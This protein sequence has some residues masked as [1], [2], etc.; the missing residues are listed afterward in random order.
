MNDDTRWS[1]RL[2]LHKDDAVVLALLPQ[3][4]A[5]TPESRHGA[6]KY[7]SWTVI[8]PIRKK[9]MPRQSSSLWVIEI[10]GDVPGDTR[11]GYQAGRELCAMGKPELHV[12]ECCCC[13]CGEFGLLGF[14]FA[15]AVTGFEFA[16]AMRR[17]VVSSLCGRR[18]CSSS[19]A[20]PAQLG[21][22][23]ELT[24]PVSTHGEIGEVSGIPEEHLKRKVR[25]Q[26]S[27]SCISRS[28]DP[29]DACLHFSACDRKT[30]TP[31]FE[32]SMQVVIY[33]PSRCTTQSGPAPNEWK[34]SFESVNK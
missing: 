19:S 3:F 4:S 11:G 5:P 29:F 16:M 22:V 31:I 20:G 12:L 21:G 27:C 8:L 18:F 24:K 30:L 10:P 2:A 17:L 6:P 1:Y 9:V 34:I 13:R 23:Q 15:V 25:G 32:F 26:F 33:S 14:E 7:C 28:R